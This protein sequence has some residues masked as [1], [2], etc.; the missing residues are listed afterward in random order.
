VGPEDFVAVALPR[1]EV[2]IVAVLAVL[3]AGAA[4]FSV[5][6]H[7]PAER[8]AFM[9]K[10]VRP[11]LVLATTGSSTLGPRDTDVP[12]MMLY[13]LSAFGPDSECAGGNLTDDDRVAPLQPAHPMYVIYTSGSTGEPKGVVVTHAN[14]ANLLT[15]LGKRFGL[16]S[17]D[18]MLASSVL[19]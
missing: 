10:D 19:G 1:T 2:M 14:L 18:R 5:D 13:D 16:G 4:Y 15:D 9:V 12:V 11:E 8:V 3:K 7:L 17:G 6:G